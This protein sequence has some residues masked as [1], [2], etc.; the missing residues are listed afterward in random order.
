[1]HELKNSSST[2]LLGIILGLHLQSVV[3]PESAAMG[4]DSEETKTASDAGVAVAATAE[5]DS[6]ATLS[7]EALSDVTPSLSDKL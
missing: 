6:E 1:M 2:I 7:D 5:G 4:S 3:C